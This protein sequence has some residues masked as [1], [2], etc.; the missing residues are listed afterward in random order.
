MLQAA[1]RFPQLYLLGTAN[2]PVP[3]SS[4]I[5]ETP[6]EVPVSS[7]ASACISQGIKIKGEVTGSEDLFVDDPVDKAE[8]AFQWELDHRAKRHA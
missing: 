2:T 5:R 3:I 4:P 7:K 8:N 1:P 6:K